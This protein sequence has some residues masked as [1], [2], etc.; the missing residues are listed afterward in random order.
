M[1]RPAPPRVFAACLYCT[2]NRVKCP[3]TLLGGTYPC[4]RCIDKDQDLNACVPHRQ[5][6]D[7]VPGVSG[8]SHVRPYNNKKG[9]VTRTSSSKKA[10]PRQQKSSAAPSRPVRT[11]RSGVLKAGHDPEEDETREVESSEDDD[12]VSSR[13]TRARK[14]EISR[15]GI[16]PEAAQIAGINAEFTAFQQ[17]TLGELR[18]AFAEERPLMQADGQRRLFEPPP[19]AGHMVIGDLLDLGRMG[20]SN[21]PVKKQQPGTDEGY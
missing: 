21:V 15:T 20:G 4:Q 8:A 3:A 7:W 16:D 10:A 17:M 1:S 2:G 13:Y 11:A 9:S 14:E 5:H 19:G 18:Q 6:P 12:T